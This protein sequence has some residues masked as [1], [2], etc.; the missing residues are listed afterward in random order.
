MALFP[1]SFID[2]LKLHA[3]IVQIIQE[4]VSLKREGRT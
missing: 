1:Q 3:N 2:D 4:Y